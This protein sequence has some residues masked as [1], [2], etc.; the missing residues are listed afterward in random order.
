MKKLLILLS[1]LFIILHVS[2]CIFSGDDKAD[3]KADSVAKALVGTWGWPI[4]GGVYST[5]TLRSN[6]RF[7]RHD[8]EIEKDGSRTL[9]WSG[10]GEFGVE[11]KEEGYNADKIYLNFW[12]EHLELR[13]TT[14][15]TFSINGNKLTLDGTVLTRE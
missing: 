11:L 6:G 13:S 3:S 8:Y 5:L 12:D 7:A 15:Y 2:G 14:Y 4:W 10:G 1:V 9:K